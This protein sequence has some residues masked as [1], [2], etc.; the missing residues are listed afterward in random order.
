[1]RTI[2]EVVWVD[3]RNTCVCLGPRLHQIKKWLVSWFN[4][5]WF[6]LGC[7]KVAPPKAMICLDGME[8]TLH[9]EWPNKIVV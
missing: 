7:F 3:E 6:V 8:F 2:G 9:R 1:M 4:L 5:S